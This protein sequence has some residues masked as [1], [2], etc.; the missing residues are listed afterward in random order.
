MYPAFPAVSAFSLTTANAKLRQSA[1]C[2]NDQRLACAVSRRRM[3]VPFSSPQP[4]AVGWLQTCCC[5]PTFNAP[6]LPVSLP[7]ADGFQYAAPLNRGA[8][9]VNRGS[10]CE[11]ESIKPHSS[12]SPKP[13]FMVSLPSKLVVERLTR[14]CTTAPAACFLPNPSGVRQSCH[15]QPPQT[16]VGTPV[17]H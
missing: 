11:N 9:A 10:L 3:V 13:H 4:P 17:H 6:L 16:A 8:A 5:W 15:A 14:K 1:Y 7:F 12:R 2:I